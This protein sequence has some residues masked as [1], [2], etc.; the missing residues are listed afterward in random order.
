MSQL[1]R[2]TMDWHGEGQPLLV[3]DFLKT[4]K[5]KTAYEVITMRPVKGNPT[6]FKLGC[7]RWSPNDVPE[8]KTVHLFYWYKR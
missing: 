6:R 1:A 5:G 3:G 7:E 2:L 4:A 8:W